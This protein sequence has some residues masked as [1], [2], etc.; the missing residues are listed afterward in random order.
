MMR[1]FRQLVNCIPGDSPKVDTVAD[2]AHV[3]L[4]PFPDQPIP[5]MTVSAAGPDLDSAEGGDLNPP[6][7]LT[8]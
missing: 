8:T 7:G 5:E 1:Q 6:F 2:S 3:T 4:A